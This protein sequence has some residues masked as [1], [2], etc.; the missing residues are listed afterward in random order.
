V[1]IILGILLG[2]L[3]GFLFPIVHDHVSKF[4][5]GCNLYGMGFTGGLI[6][7]VFIA[8]LASLGIEVT[9]VTLSSSGD[10]NLPL[11]I[12]LY[13]LSLF[14]ILCGLFF[15][16]T[17]KL[18]S[19]MLSVTKT[20]G[21]FP[22][23]YYK[24]Y[25]ANIYVKM[26]ALCALGT[27]IVLI[28]GAQL[29][30][31]TMAGILTMTGFGSFGKHMKN[32]VPVL[33]G[34]ILAAGLS[35]GGVAD[36]KNML[37]VLFSAGLSPISG[38]YGTAW[39]VLAGFLHVGIVHHI[40]Y[41]SSGLNLYNN[42]FAAGFVAILLVSVLDTFAEIKASYSGVYKMKNIVKKHRPKRRRND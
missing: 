40:G 31:P 27:S 19:D 29:N 5:R 28:S 34:S 18:K 32:T 33:I 24:D 3:S 38:K 26:G 22:S 35:Q 23:D 25:G 14:L 7:T 8:V 16:E 37:A 41:L 4:A 13:T 42:G 1:N 39:G 12:L 10:N 9:M 6:A 2:T 21:V 30:G 15:G 20:T 11:G 17:K 36:S